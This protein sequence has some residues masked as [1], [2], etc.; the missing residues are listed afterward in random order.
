MSAF[1]TASLTV[2]RTSPHLNLPGIIYIYAA[3]NAQ[4]LLFDYPVKK[5]IARRN[6][7]QYQQ[8]SIDVN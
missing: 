8:T 5:T 3:D 2:S 1:N 7:K 6:I 4:L